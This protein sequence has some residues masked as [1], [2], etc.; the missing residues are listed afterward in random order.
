MLPTV[1]LLSPLQLDLSPAKLSQSTEDLALAETMY[2][3][4]L[5][6]VMMEVFAATN[7][8]NLKLLE[9]LAE[10][11]LEFV[12]F[13]MFALEHLPLVPIVLLLPEHLAELLLVSVI[14]QRPVLDPVHRAQ[15]I[16]SREQML[17]AE[18]A[19]AFVISLKTV[20]EMLPIALQTPSTK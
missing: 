19:L 8:A 10:T 11:P 17:S 7:T 14:F 12:M 13:L 15:Q 18:T 1:Q 3:T 6:F 4:V 20:Q 5:K 16:P 9:P 2:W